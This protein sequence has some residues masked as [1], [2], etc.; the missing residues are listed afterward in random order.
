MAAVR[1]ERQC[2]SFVSA[3][4]KL[5]TGPSRDRRTP[6]PSLRRNLTLIFLPV[7][8]TL[9]PEAR[10]HRGMPLANPRPVTRAFGAVHGPPGR[11]FTGNAADDEKGSGSRRGTMK[12]GLRQSMLSI[13]VFVIVLAGLVFVDPR[14]RDRFGALVSGGDGAS[15]VGDRVGDLGNALMTAVRYQSIENAPLLIFATVG[16]VLFV[17]MVRT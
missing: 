14:V 5:V 12:A 16:A 17:F 13:T 2:L 9:D 1:Y 3:T 6:G 8:I 11:F 7:A 10:S 4:A 15:S